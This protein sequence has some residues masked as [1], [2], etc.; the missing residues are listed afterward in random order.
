MYVTNYVLHAPSIAPVALVALV[1]RHQ[2]IPG[3]AEMPALLYVGQRC[4]SD[5][6]EHIEFKTHMKNSTCEVT[7]RVE[8]DVLVRQMQP[9]SQ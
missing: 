3:V 4:T 7:L 1:L 6:N 2:S 9:L 8:G 5:E